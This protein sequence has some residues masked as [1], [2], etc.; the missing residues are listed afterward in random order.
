M[1]GIRYYSILA[2]GL[3][4]SYGIIYL[5][6]FFFGAES[7]KN[8]LMVLTGIYLLNLIISWLGWAKRSFR[9]R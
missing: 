5:V 2:V 1:N 4:V 8:A 6:L 7:F 9:K 3:I